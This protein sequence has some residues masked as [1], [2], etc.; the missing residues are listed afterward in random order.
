M[1][2]AEQ[3]R[4]RNEEKAEQLKA[5][6]ERL[7]AEMAS[8]VKRPKMAAEPAA[9]RK[10]PKAN[11]APAGKKEAKALADPQASLFELQMT[12]CISESDRVERW[13]WDEPRDWS[14]EEFEGDIQPALNEMQRLTWG[15]ILNEHKVPAK[16]NRLVP[17]HHGQAVS[18]L[19]A[20]A[21][22]RWLHLQLEQYDEAFRFR[23]GNKKRA[24][25]VRLQHHF[26]LIWWERQHRIYQVDP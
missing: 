8:F 17:R 13:S 2:R 5:S 23:C 16:G 21:R 11:V 1:S 18:S 20:E 24:W 26:Y 4:L 6:N 14:N 10:E 25:G 7:K 9:L 22:D 12:W 3:R 15:V 19:S